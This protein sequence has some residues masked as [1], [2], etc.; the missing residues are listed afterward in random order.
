VRVFENLDELIAAKGEHLGYTEWQEITQDQVNLFADATDD[1]QWI[2]V[3]LDRAKAGPFKG[4]IVHG[5]M[6]LSLIP[7][8]GWQL[9]KVK[10]LSMGINYGLNKVRF[11]S[12]VPVGARVRAGGEVLDAKPGKQGTQVFMR[13]TIEIE[14][15]DKPA[16]VAETIAVMVA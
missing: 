11:P 14:G 8:F 7:Q 5:Y 9:Y 1:H 6:T 10:N 12:V 15:Y 13:I 3:D 2:H 4:T 16:C